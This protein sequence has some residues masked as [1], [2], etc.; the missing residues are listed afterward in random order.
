MKRKCLAIVLVICITV[1]LE[2]TY[3]AAEETTGGTY[4]AD[5][6]NELGLFE[7]GNSGYELDRRPT[8][9]E[10]LVML[11]RLLGKEK[12][13]LT[14]KT[15]SIFTDVPD[16]AKSYVN[17][18]N[19][20]GLTKGIS[21]DKFGTDNILSLKD[22]STFVLRAL[23]YNDKEGDFTWDNSVDKAM[24]TGI[25]K[26]DDN[27]EKG[28]F[29]RGDVVKLSFNAL[30]ADLKDGSKSLANLLI[31]KGVL[32][33][34]ASEKL[35]MR[36]K[37]EEFGAAGN[38]TVDDS[39]VL[40]NMLNS[41]EDGDIIDLNGLTYNL[42]GQTIN[43]PKSVKFIGP[44]KLINGKFN[45]SHL[46]G[47]NF[48]TITTE[49]FCISIVKSSDIS[50]TNSSFTKVKE[51][52]DGFISVKATC[53]NVDISNNSF[54]DI[55]YKTSATTFGSG[56]KITAIETEMRNFKITDNKFEHIHGPAAVW[57]GGTNSTLKDITI[58]S[59]IINN[60]ESFGIE[61]YQFNGRLWVTSINIHDN[62]ISNVGAIREYN[63]GNGSTGIYNNLEEGTELNAYDNDIRH[64][65]EVGIEGYYTQVRDNYI[66]DSGA[67][68][69]YHPIKDSSGIYTTGPKVTGNTIVNPGYY[70]GI[71]KFSS[72]F[73][74]DR[75]I[76]NNTIKNVFNYWEAGKSYNA[77][78]L[79]VAG[80][81]WYRCIQ[82]GVSGTQAPSGK[83]AG[84]KDGSVIWD[85]KKPFAQTGITLHA[86]TG[87][88]HI[89]I[90]NNTIIDFPNCIFL[91]DLNNNIAISGNTHTVNGLTKGEEIKFLAGYGNRSGDTI[92]IQE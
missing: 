92:S 53:Y 26:V 46:N 12:E 72:G 11:I 40:I 51:D 29:T 6:L 71:H 86:V 36:Y 58:S 67:D 31:E 10:G 27:F 8:R 48:D 45:F 52:V 70:G 28:I 38:G 1:S 13:T 15:A 79:V 37:P 73:I 81:C 50:I 41:A 17:F 54:E 60:T 33:S 88:D 18:A 44:G 16:W 56:I 24:A 35:L 89:Y 90:K 34:S 14:N 85:Y 69:L 57:L 82:A 62:T 65:L 75:D 19:E 4:Y 49:N 55:E 20:Q 22:Y 87:V 84:I 42:G 39:K 23:G 64:V 59:N 9:V 25:L 83:E 32:D 77:S 68:Q 78:D 47:F 91:S 63:Y 43:L 80:G 66:E 76:E 5:I 30:K 3:L 2:T 7:G 74:S 21:N 61:L